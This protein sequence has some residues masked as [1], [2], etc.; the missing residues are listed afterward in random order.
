M[1][2][3]L[4]VWPHGS[5]IYAHGLHLEEIPWV[6]CY[7]RTGGV[8]ERLLRAIYWSLDMSRSRGVAIMASLHVNIERELGNNS[9]MAQ[10]ALLIHLRN[11]EIE[12]NSST[13]CWTVIA[14]MFKCNLL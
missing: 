1:N 14:A 3:S 11:K 2:R 12:S 8:R 9:C 7:G 4:G 13:T 10:G 6:H 5:I